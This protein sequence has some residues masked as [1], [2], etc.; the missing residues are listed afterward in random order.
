L[1]DELRKEF[2]TSVL[3]ISH[4]LALVSNYTDEI[5]V[6]YSGHI[7]EEAAREEFFKNP[8]HPYS[9]ALLNSLPQ[10]NP[11]LKLKTI[12]GTPP[13]I[14]EKISGCRFHPRCDFCKKDICTAESPSLRE[15]SPKHFSACHIK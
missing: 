11:Y 13:G 8:M 2:N 14:Q 1:I 9:L 7:V 15:K 3:L 10:K 5:S 4:D 12:E 6:M